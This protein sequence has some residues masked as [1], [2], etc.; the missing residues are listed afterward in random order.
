M[1]YKV[2]LQ[3]FGDVWTSF[4]QRIPIFL[5][6]VLKDYRRQKRKGY[7]DRTTK[8][9][10]CVWAESRSPPGA[11]PSADKA[12]TYQSA[13]LSWLL[14]H[15]HTKLNETWRQ[16]TGVGP[17]LKNSHFTRSSVCIKHWWLEIWREI[18]IWTHHNVLSGWN[19]SELHMQEI[20]IWHRN[21]L[22]Y[23]KRP[24]LQM[25]H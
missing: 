19:E 24:N 5:L 14:P 1:L 12:H 4:I 6:M 3:S 7:K 21:S 10:L 16:I 23:V 8:K 2:L 18:L 11:Q 22:N 9:P 25:S 15:F 17:F 13:P 20:S